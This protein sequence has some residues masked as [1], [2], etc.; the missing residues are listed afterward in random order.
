MANIDRNSLNQLPFIFA[1]R[2]PLTSANR[3][4]VSGMSNHT[5][6]LSKVRSKIGMSPVV[7][8]TGLARSNSTRGLVKRTTTSKDGLVRSGSM[9][10]TAGAPKPR[11]S[12]SGLSSLRATKK[13]EVISATTT[14][15]SMP[16]TAITSTTKPKEP[17]K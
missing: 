9:A 16:S 5:P 12:L 13:N 14:R 6:D 8:A 10:A 4:S 15:R 17:F 7:A 11:T 3:T 1:D 2:K